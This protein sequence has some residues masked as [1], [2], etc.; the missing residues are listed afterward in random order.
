[1]SIDND[2][3]QFVELIYGAVVLRD[4]CSF[5][6]IFQYDTIAENPTSR[7]NRNGKR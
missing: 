6:F 4:N 5:S 1:M 7:G 3:F 2:K